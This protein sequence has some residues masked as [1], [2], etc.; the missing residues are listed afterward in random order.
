MEIGIAVDI[1]GIGA[2][3]VLQLLI[4]RYNADKI[5]EQVQGGDHI[6]EEY[7]RPMSSWR[8]NSGLKSG[9]PS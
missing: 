7:T 6:A 4:Y 8:L 3:R 5:I 9:L 1:H 2:I